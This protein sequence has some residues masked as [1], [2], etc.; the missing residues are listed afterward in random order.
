MRQ[1]NGL[2]EEEYSKASRERYKVRREA[3]ADPIDRE[4]GR[5]MRRVFCFDPNGD[6]R[7]EKVLDP[8]PYHPDKGT[9]L[10]TRKPRNLEWL[11]EIAR[12]TEPNPYTSQ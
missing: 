9:I 10:A 6:I 1:S 8:A 11:V 7:F 4:I 12:F 5:E 3:V 2:L